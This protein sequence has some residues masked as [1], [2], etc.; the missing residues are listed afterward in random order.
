ML[1]L[2]PV[3]DAEIAGLFD[4][5]AWIAAMARF[6]HALAQA[7]GQLGLIPTEAARAIA[8]ALS[9]PAVS[10]D[11]VAA[12]ALHDGNPAIPFVR[13]VGQGADDPAVAAWLHYGATSQDL[14]DTAL[15]LM[16][17][18]A[19]DILSVRLM[20]VGDRLAALAE[21]ERDTV[22]AARTLGQ[23]ALPTTFGAKAAFWLDPLVR[24][25][26]RLAAVRREAV[27]LQ[28]GGAVGTLA[29]FPAPAAARLSA[30][31]GRRLGLAVPSVPWHGARD[32]VVAI[33]TV[34]AE[35]GAACGKLARD[36][37][38]LMQTEIAELAEGH[39]GGSSTLPHKRNPVLTQ[40]ICAAQQAL[41]GLPGRALTA[42]IG[43]QERAAGPWHGEWA[44]IPQA[45]E[46]CGAA[47]AATEAL[48]CD[49]VVDRDR[50]GRN[51]DVT[52][53]LIF[54]ERLSF[55][56]A[57]SLGRDRAK[58]LVADLCRQSLADGIGLRDAAAAAPAVGSVLSP[59]A[60]GAVFDPLAATGQAGAVVDAV[61]ARWR[62][63][64]DGGSETP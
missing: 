40:R 41:A 25:R 47:L 2:V 21:A 9:P 60:L 50:M 14:V 37:Q 28:F 45:A 49:L 56:L 5:P 58:A 7:Q 34:L 26:D 1:H 20:R 23:H 24:H 8:Q 6:E 22:I 59:A 43:E 61:V 46:G 19:L 29:A 36:M 10:P 64:A 39:P 4:G 30:E 32:R 18:Q 44:L 27:A 33:V 51:L 31:M 15:M 38:L 3:A 53:G 17:A 52:D 12:A 62:G 57:P 54:A 63:V 13:L 16:A 55:A 35:I 48:L 11:A 42:A